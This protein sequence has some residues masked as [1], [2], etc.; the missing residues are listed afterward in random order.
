MKILIDDFRIL[1]PSRPP[2][3]DVIVRNY[4]AAEEL[5]ALLGSREELPKH[6]LYVDHDLGHWDEKKNGYTLMCQIEE[7]AFAYGD[8]AFRF[9][10][11]SITCV[12]DNGAGR[13]KI[14]Q[15]IDKLYRR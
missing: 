10:P 11:K 15:I 1:I 8:Q 6:D 7:E 4:E 3:P 14:Q 13:R 2:H 12:S 9:L 5:L